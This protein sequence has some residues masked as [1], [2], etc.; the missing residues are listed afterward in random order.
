MG[1]FEQISVDINRGKIAYPELKGF[2]LDR[3]RMY[4]EAGRFLSYCGGNLEMAVRHAIHQQLA[5]HLG[6][7]HFLAR[8]R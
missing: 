7:E 8:V 3:P 6:V 1:L 2:E 4:A 5:N